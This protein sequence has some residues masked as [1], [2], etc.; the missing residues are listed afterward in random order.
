M[1]AGSKP[2]GEAKRGRP[3]AG[4][5][6]TGRRARGPHT[7]PLSEHRAGNDLAVQQLA[8][9]MLAHQEKQFQLPL[10]RRRVLFRG[11][12]SVMGKRK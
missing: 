1:H 11:R 5:V 10:Q 2:P 9:E 7:A 6:E 12:G 4:G 3:L 8:A